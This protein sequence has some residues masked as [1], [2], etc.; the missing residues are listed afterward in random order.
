[1]QEELIT[2]ET[3]K[4]AK[5]KGFDIKCVNYF[6]EDGESKENELTGTNG[7]YGEE[8]CLSIGEFQENWNDKF[9][10]KKNGDRCFGCSKKDGYLETFSRPTQA[11][12]QRWL[13]EV[14]KIDIEISVHLRGG[15][16]LYRAD[17]Y[18]EAFHE[19]ELKE[20]ETHE[21]ALEAGLLEALK[22]IK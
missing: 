7:Y 13:R 21:Q 8:Y 11:L 1:M 3:A 18:I 19:K 10:T 6:F 5:E 14:H 20:E 12:L 9:L 2:F 17:I 22:L 4:S 16:R 15:D